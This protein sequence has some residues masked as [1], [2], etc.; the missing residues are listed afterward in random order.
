MQLDLP[1]SKTDLRAIGK[2]R[3]H[4]CTC[5]SALCPVATAKRGQATSVAVAADG[6]LIAD[7]E[8]RN[9]L[10]NVIAESFKRVALAAGMNSGLRLTGHAGRV[11]GSTSGAFGSSAHGATRR[12]ASTSAKPTSIPAPWHHNGRGYGTRRARGK[13]PFTNAMCLILRARRTWG[14]QLSNILPSPNSR[15]TCKPGD[16]SQ[17]RSH[18]VQTSLTRTLSRLSRGAR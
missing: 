17:K 12:Y 15:P 5:P 9:L 14:S 4:T 13:K 8:G 3:C 18:L 11:T 7:L 16:W 1:V 6:P 2:F 10:K